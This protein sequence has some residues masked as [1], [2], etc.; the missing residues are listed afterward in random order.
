MTERIRIGELASRCGVTRDTIRFYERAG[1]LP[2]PRRTATRH[3][4]YDQKTAQQLRFVRRAQDLGLTLDDIRQ[5]LELRESDS[6][7]AARRMSEILR[8]RLEAIT[9]RITAFEQHRSRLENAIR[10]M[11]EKPD[12]NRLFQE[13]E[14]DDDRSLKEA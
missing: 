7:M 13:F 9:Q 11:G 2:K 6:P 12:G 14:S 8:A 4:I 10:D 3:R 1:L 5:L